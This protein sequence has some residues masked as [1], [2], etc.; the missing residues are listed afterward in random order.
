ML[1]RQRERG[2]VSAAPEQSDIG[3]LIAQGLLDGVGR[4]PHWAAELLPS[5]AR[6]RLRSYR[7]G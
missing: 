1:P 4:V 3:Q 5:R 2:W 7:R 6:V